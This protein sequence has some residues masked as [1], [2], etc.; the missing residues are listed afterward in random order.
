MDEIVASWTA[1][2]RAGIGHD[3]EFHSFIHRGEG[4][5]PILEQTYRLTGAQCR[6]WYQLAAGIYP[7]Q[8]CSVQISTVSSY[9]C[10]F[11]LEE[12][13]TRTLHES[14]HSFLTHSL[15]HTMRYG[16]TQ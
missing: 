14:L 1:G 5:Q 6:V 10:P 16:Q 2:G 7:T 8:A 15:G 4:V 12:L 3:T 13:E 9:I 11:C